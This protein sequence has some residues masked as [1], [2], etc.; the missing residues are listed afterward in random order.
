MQSETGQI[1]ATIAHREQK[2]EGVITQI[3]SILSSISL[4]SFHFDIAMVLRE[5]L[6]INSIMT[7]SEIWHNVKL[8]HV[9]C[10]EKLDRQLLRKIVNDHSKTA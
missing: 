7:N 8:S 10:L 5:A 6:F 2:A 3:S 9:Q 4:G 1:D